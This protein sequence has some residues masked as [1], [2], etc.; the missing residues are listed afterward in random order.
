MMLFFMLDDHGQASC[1]S[2]LAH[3][4]MT[5]CANK[6]IIDRPPYAMQC[7]YPIN[8]DMATP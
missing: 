5:L 1:A 6:H 2:Y 8:D 7:A 3:E 4:V